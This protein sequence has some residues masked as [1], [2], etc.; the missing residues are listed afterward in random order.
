VTNL[1][2]NEQR[3]SLR[4]LRPRQ[5]AAVLEIREAVRQGH[6]RIIMQA[7]TGMGKTL[8]AAHMIT[9]AMSKS[10]RVLF[11]C[12]AITLVD[13]TL[14]SFEA[15]GI[16]NIGIMQA[17]H[18]RTDWLARLQIASVQTLIR[19]ELPDVDLIFIDEV[20]LN[21]DGLGKLLDGPWRDKIAIG[22]SATPWSKG[23]GLRW[24]K[25]IVAATIQ[26]L[27]EDEHLSPFQ[28]Y[29]PCK[30][31]DRSQI[32]VIAGEFQEKS[33]GIAMIGAT[34]VGDIVKTWKEKSTQEKTFM[35]CVNRA[36]AKEQMGAF[37][38][39]GIP[40]GYIDANTPRE[41]R[42]KQ[43]AK[44]RNGEIAGIASIGCLIAG[45]DEDVRT[46]I[47]AAPTK[48]EIRHVQKIGR[49]LRTAPGKEVC[50]ILDHAGN[51]LELGLV[52]DIYHDTL[53][54][55]KPNEK[56]EA[57]EGELRPSKP[58]KC[59][60]CNALIPKGMVKC[61]ACGTVERVTSDIEHREGELAVYG[62]QPKKG[63]SSKREYSMQE[64]QE[65]YSGMIWIAKEGG[66]PEGMAAHRFREKFGTW[67]RCLRR[68]ASPPSFECE[69]FDRHCRIKWAKSMKSKEV[70]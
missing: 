68:V 2:D 27:I 12:P 62:S 48:S 21:F 34:I 54:M 23:L 25:L 38:D 18:E 6:K 24:S 43:F 57:Y 3:V 56:G 13:Q 63:P 11:T 45:V 64:K 36:H 60:V 33:A 8:C 1:F 22:L 65:F 55:R 69:Q 30:D 49:G 9:G 32:K 15:D 26:E 35:F 14:K 7:P 47:D 29:V 41:V 5:N 20:H 67:P 37:I 46:I 31:F 52:T 40:F 53:D 50:T 17:Q 42:T 39:S 19:R 16:R 58:H 59:V 66:N 44:M 51:A 70:K 61:P 4:P 10:N 28:V